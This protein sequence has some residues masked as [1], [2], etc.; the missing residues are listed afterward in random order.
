MAGYFEYRSLQ[1]G[2][3]RIMSINLSM[4]FTF[5]ERPSDPAL[6]P[7]IKAFWYLRIKSKT[8]LSPLNATPIPEQCLYFYPKEKPQA[9]FSGE[10]F[11]IAPSATLFG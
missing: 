6:Q 2:E 4:I 5:L 10:K 8:P 7:F 1:S 3:H 11:T 9:L